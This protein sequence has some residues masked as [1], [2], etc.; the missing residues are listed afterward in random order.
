[1]ESFSQTEITSSLVRSLWIDRPAE[2]HKGTFGH[3]LSVCG[4]HGMMG[5]AVLAARAAL[6]SGIGKITVHI[7]E[8]AHTIF[9]IAVPEA[10]IDFDTNSS[11]HWA[12]PI[13]THPYQS[14]II[15]CGIG[16]EGETQWALRTQLQMLTMQHNE[17]GT[18]K[19]LVDADGLNIIA[20]DYQ[21][22]SLLPQNAIL[23]PH[24]KEMKR[25]CLAIELPCDRDEQLFSS[26]HRLAADLHL[27]I[28][29]KSARTHVFTA[30]G[31]VYVNAQNG[32]S[33]MATAG[34]GD[35]LAGLIGGLLAQG[36]CPDA[37]AVIGVF[38]HAVSGDLAARSL[39]EH[40]LIASDIVEHLPNAF[41]SV[42]SP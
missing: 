20:E 28:V 15:G 24:I 38:L 19:L 17:D 30:Q 32:N 40:S 29:L 7:P 3:V 23:T 34:S 5:A 39:G 2:G 18:P 42:H 11:T 9:Q 26:T 33:G 22:L 6:R 27:N 16:R 21:M 8:R 41:L 37:A 36:Y 4:Q 1:M 35:V 12:T 10:I 13:D 25:L 31:K 14:V